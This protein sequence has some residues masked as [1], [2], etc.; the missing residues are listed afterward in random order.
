MNCYAI[1]HMNL[2]RCISLNNSDIETDKLSSFV[3]LC[4]ERLTALFT[5]SDHDEHAIP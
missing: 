4:G 3:T 2:L 5:S 1:V